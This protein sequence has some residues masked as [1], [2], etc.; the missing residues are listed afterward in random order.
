MVAHANNCGR[1]PDGNWHA[2]CRWLRMRP[3]LVLSRFLVV[4]VA[5]A[6]LAATI[7]PPRLPSLSLSIATPSFQLSVAL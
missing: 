4:A 7:S 3:N 5:T 6:A 1:R 2:P